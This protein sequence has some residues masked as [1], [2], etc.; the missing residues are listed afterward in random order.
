NESR[1]YTLKEQPPTVVPVQPVNVVESAS[2]STITTGPIKAVISKTTFNL[3]DE[4]WYDENNNGTF[5]PA[6][7]MI[8]PTNDDNLPLRAGTSSGAVQG[9]AQAGRG[10]PTAYVWETLGPLRSTLRVEGTYGNPADPLLRYTT[11]LTFYAGRTDVNIEHVLRNS[12]ATEER[13]VKVQ[14]AKLIA[15]G[16]GTNVRATKS[17]SQLWSNVGSFGTEVEL[18]PATLDVSTQYDPNA[19]PYVSRQNT[20]I[21]VDSNGGMLVGDW[22]YHGITTRLEFSDNLSPAEQSQAATRAADRLVALAPANW[23]SELGAFGSEKFG[24]LSEEQETYQRWG[25]QW[26]TPGNLL[27]SAEP[28]IGRVKNSFRIDWNSF[29][30]GDLEADDVWMNLMMYIRTRSRGYLDRADGWAR[31]YKWEYTWRSDGFAYNRPEFWSGPARPTVFPRT[32]LPAGSLTVND[33]NY[34]NY[35]IKYFGKNDGNH[36]WNGGLIDYY[37]LFG[38]LD[39]LTAA[40]DTAEQSKQ[41]SDWRTPGASNAWI[42]GN[43]RGEGRQMYN[44]LRVYE[45]TLENAWLSA[46]THI[47]NM[48]MQTPYWDARGFYYGDTNGTT[49]NN[50]NLRYPNAKYFSGFMLG[51]VSQTFYR[52]WLI[53]GDDAVRARII[54]M[55]DFAL[56]SGHGPEGYTGDNTL[57]DWPTPGN[58]IHMTY[59]EFRN[60]NPTYHYSYSSS[61]TAF[62]DTLVIAY[63]FTGN[64]NYLQ[65]AKFFWSKSSKRRG[66]NPFDQ[67]TADDFHVGR[68]LNSLDGWNEWST[69]FPSNGDLTSAQFLF[70]DA[71]RADETPPGTITD[72]RFGN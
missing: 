22:S 2:T 41:H 57:I 30:A 31:Y 51:V 37:Y 50:V 9:T 6:E 40:T 69:L 68:F 59:D 33:T 62:I 53:T 71:I 7:Q 65:K 26:P 45:A 60:D 11:R 56:N 15:S 1:T 27:Y 38:D 70:Y 63:R 39:A 66:T 12:I 67:L 20:I 36:T 52:Y 19:N 48:F 24:T 49:L 5:E 8:A 29:D 58:I 10:V 13:Y 55:A 46:T 21:D 4:F 25:W 42:G 16:A 32:D 28:Y 35:N 72:L 64:V 23:Y 34:I 61:S 44:T 47:R 43:V 3:F 14:S 54:S 17:G 18:I